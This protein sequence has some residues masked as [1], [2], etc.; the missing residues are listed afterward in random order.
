M[1]RSTYISENTTQNQIDFMLMLD[2]NELDIF[3]LEEIKRIASSEFK[4]INEIIENLVH[5][6]LLSRIERGKYCRYNFRDENVIGCKLS[7][8]SAIGY[9]SALNKHGLTEQFP[10]SIFI[11]TTK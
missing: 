7:E 9:W 1:A 8:G 11:Q 4:N 10:N 2:D 6:K 5:K 3:T